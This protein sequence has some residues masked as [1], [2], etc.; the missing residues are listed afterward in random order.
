MSGKVLSSNRL[1]GRKRPVGKI[2]DDTICYFN[3][4]SKADVSQLYGREP[5]TKTCKKELKSKNGKVP[6]GK[7]PVG[8]T[9]GYRYGR[10]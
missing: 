3:V 8:E 1:V 7:R 6:L 4:R 5:K 9:S 10:G 2:Q